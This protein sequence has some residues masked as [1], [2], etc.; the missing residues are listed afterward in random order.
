MTQNDRITLNECRYVKKCVELG[1]RFAISI[2]FS[3]RL[4]PLIWMS[5]KAMSH[6]RL[7]RGRGKKRKERLINQIIVLNETKWSTLKYNGTQGI[8]MDQHQ[9]Q[10]PAVLGHP[11]KGCK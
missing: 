8:H 3:S 4:T 10:V 1:Y 7:S 2:F 6:M 11:P 5:C 9:N